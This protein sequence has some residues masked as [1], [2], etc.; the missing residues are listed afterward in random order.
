MQLLTTT[1][2][3]TVIHKDRT[4]GNSPRQRS[5]ALQITKKLFQKGNLE[6]KWDTYL[7]CLELMFTHKVLVAIPTRIGDFTDFFS[8]TFPQTMKRNHSVLSSD[9]GSLWR[10][11]YLFEPKNNNNN[12]NRKAMKWQLFITL[13]SLIGCTAWNT[14]I[15]PLLLWLKAILP[16]FFPPE[17]RFRFQNGGCVKSAY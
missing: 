4:S 3:F 1:F 10:L 11:I 2:L 14:T 16:G 7:L 15:W 5:L 17:P 13:F 6:N 8:R 12:N 9:G